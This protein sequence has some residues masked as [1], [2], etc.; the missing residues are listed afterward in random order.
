MAESLRSPEEEAFGEWMG[1][2]E[3]CAD[4]V[5]DECGGLEAAIQWC[6]KW[7]HRPHFAAVLEVLKCRKDVLKQAEAAVE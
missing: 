7:A 3:H 6:G 4:A 5:V 1:Q 2:I